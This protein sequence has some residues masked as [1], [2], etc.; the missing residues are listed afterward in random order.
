MKS[1]KILF[2]LLTS[3]TLFSCEEEILYFVDNT[4]PAVPTNITTDTGDNLVLISWDHVNDPD[5]SG[6]AVYYSDKYDGEYN[7]LGTTLESG[8]VDYGAANGETYFYA[9]ASYDLSGNESDL[10]YDV[11]YDTP[12]PEGFDYAIFDYKYIPDNSGY[13]FSNYLVTNYASLETDFF[14][15]NDN[16]ELYLNVW[17]DSDIQNL[18]RTKNIYEIS[19]SPTEGWV[20][21][22]PGDN[23]KYVRAIRGNTYVIWT[24]DN[25]F[26][27]IRIS[28]IYTDHIEFDWA[29][30]TAPGNIELKTNRNNGSRIKPTEVKVNR[31]NKN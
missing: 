6:Y 25:H 29:Y 21:L 17:S 27:K 7:L 24:Y 28:E 2:L 11:V 9:V 12:R 23:I 3:L 19:E 14:F 20:E 10:S 30:Q 1:L 8:I 22:L 31:N 13:D 5:L 18:G 16:G 26:A 4:P 15:E